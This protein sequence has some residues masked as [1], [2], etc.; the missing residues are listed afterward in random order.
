MP[1][2]KKPR[3]C[4]KFE[5]LRVFIPCGMPREEVRYHRLAFDELEAFC[6]CDLEGMTQ[7]EAGERMGISRGTVQ[8][9]VSDARRTVAMALLHSHALVLGRD[10]DPEAADPPGRPRMVEAEG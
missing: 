2:A 6:L 1:K 5:G 3:I 7:E 8:R 10:T 4:R 9:L